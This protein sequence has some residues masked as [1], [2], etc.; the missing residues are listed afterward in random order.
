MLESISKRN[1]ADLIT[2]SFWNFGQFG[3]GTLNQGSTVPLQNNA[4]C[5]LSISDVDN[6]ELNVTFWPNPAQ[7]EVQF[8]YNDLPNATLE[9]VD[10]NGRVLYQTKTIGFSGTLSL[11]VSH[12]SRVEY[13]S[14][15]PRIPPIW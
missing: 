7:D 14:T 3:N 12:W 13:H 1:W 5:T 8:T 10:L 4:L 11:P 2:L 6:P 9:V 15:A